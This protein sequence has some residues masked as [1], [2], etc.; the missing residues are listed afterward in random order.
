MHG[1]FGL[2]PALED[3]LDLAGGHRFA[4]DEL[5]QVG[6]AEPREQRRQHGFAVVDA[7]RAART[8][9]GLLARRVGVVP[10][11]RRREIGVAEASV[12]GELHRMRRPPVLLQI[13]GRCDGVARHAAEPPRDQRGIRQPR[14][15]QAGVKPLADQIDR[16]VAQMQVD[17][18]FRIGRQKLRQ[19]RRDVPHAEGHGHREPHQAPRHRGLR[20][21]L[22]LRGLAVGE[23]PRGALGQF[24]PGVG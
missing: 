15:A 1:A 7:K 21:R 5:R 18:H 17:R 24:L 14:D 12:L 8:H 4:D 23:Q 11:V 20:Q 3:H 13:G 22:V 2:I 19:Q 6:D 9:V 16:G 10:D